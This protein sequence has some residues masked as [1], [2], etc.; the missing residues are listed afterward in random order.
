L[1]SEVQFV[2]KKV[3]VENFGSGGVAVL[4]TC[5]EDVV[6]RAATHTATK[7]KWVGAAEIGDRINREIGRV[8]WGRGLVSL[9]GLLGRG[10]E[11]MSGMSGG[12]GGD[13]IA[14]GGM[15]NNGWQGW[16]GSS[17]S[18]SGSRRRASRYGG[19]VSCEGGSEGGRLET[20]SKGAL[21]Q[22]FLRAEKEVVADSGNAKRAQGGKL[23]RASSKGGEVGGAVGKVG[24]NKLLEVG[25]KAVVELGDKI[26]AP[27]GNV[28]G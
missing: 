23:G 3:F 4:G 16:R 6:N 1:F 9:H 28:S 12:H 8:G 22:F 7:A 19:L 11:S 13:V 20:V 14:W 27:E 2:G 24:S 21:D 15:N 26:Q 18:S 17:S 5:T 25:G 10:Q